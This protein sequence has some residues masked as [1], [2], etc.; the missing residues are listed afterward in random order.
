MSAVRTALQIMTTH[1]SSGWHWLINHNPAYYQLSTEK[2]P[3]AGRY[4]GSSI[5]R[6]QFNLSPFITHISLK[7]SPYYI[8]VLTVS[9]NNVTDISVCTTIPFSLQCNEASC[10]SQNP[11][12]LYVV[13]STFKYQH[14]TCLFREN[15]PKCWSSQTL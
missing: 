3:R 4:S 7:W 14:K 15:V 8:N 12:C 2:S 13:Y 9:L 1:L 10:H 5:I 6:S 11:F